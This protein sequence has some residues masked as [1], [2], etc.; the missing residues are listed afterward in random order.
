MLKGMIKWTIISQMEKAKKYNVSFSEKKRLNKETFEFRF[1]KPRGFKFKPGQYLKMYLKI[2]RP[3]DRGTSRYFTI[4]ASPNSDFISV[5]TKII[6]SSFKK[7]LSRLKKGEEVSIFAPLGYF[8]FDATDKRTKVFLAAGIGI[9]PYHSILTTMANKKTD[10]EIFLF[11]SFSTQ[12]EIIY[13]K[14]LREIELSNKKIHIVYSLTREKIE[15]YEK[16]RIN[17]DMIRRHVPNFS[18]SQ[19]FVVGSEL[20]EKDLI[21]MLKTSGIKEES[22]FSEN[23]PGY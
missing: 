10:F 13:E 2:P 11:V 5:T 22:I 14:E 19:F 18:K 9:T 17:T 6:R 21:K 3:D 20:A 1:A 8:N 23:F 16:G 4:S 15:G 7:K 12:S